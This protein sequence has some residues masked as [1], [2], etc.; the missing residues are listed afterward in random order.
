MENVPLPKSHRKPTALRCRVTA[1]ASGIS[2]TGILISLPESI[3]SGS[4]RPNSLRGQHWKLEVGQHVESK[5]LDQCLLHF[6]CRVISGSVHKK[7]QRKIA[8][9]PLPSKPGRSLI[10]PMCREWLWNLILTVPECKP[11]SPLP[12]LSGDRY[13]K[14]NFEPIPV[15]RGSR[16]SASQIC[17]TGAP[18]LL[19]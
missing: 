11:A 7:T 8:P 16:I 2:S 6:R 14:P 3:L 15:F 17:V 13:K 4:T 19:R 9:I 18:L 12:L 5:S 1:F 10:P